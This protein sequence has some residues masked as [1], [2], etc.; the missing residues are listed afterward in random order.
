MSNNFV[1]LNV[2]ISLD[3]NDDHKINPYQL[4]KHIQE[5][6]DSNVSYYDKNTQLYE[7]AKVIGYK[8]EFD[9]FNPISFE[10]EDDPCW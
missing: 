1:N 5:Y 3:N 2:R 6:L 4:C 10:E 8:L 7:D 9:S